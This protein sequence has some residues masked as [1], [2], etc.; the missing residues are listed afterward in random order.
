MSGNAACPQTEHSGT[1]RA[2]PLAAASEGHRS[3]LA[4]STVWCLTSGTPLLPESCIKEDTPRPQL[5]GKRPTPF[6]GFILYETEIK[7]AAS[8]TPRR[9]ETGLLGP[10]ARPDLEAGC[11]EGSS[12][13]AGPWPGWGS[14][15]EEGSPGMGKW[16]QATA[17]E[18]GP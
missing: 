10:W 16:R 6:F 4:L 18:P 2:H 12:G 13:A 14:E 5:T 17:W 15:Q 9:G 7:S 11:G 8:V 3:S 1:Q